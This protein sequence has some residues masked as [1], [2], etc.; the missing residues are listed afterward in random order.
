MLSQS[1][2]LNV[3]FSSGRKVCI[4]LDS[5]IRVNEHDMFITYLPTKRHSLIVSPRVC[6]DDVRSAYRSTGSISLTVID[7]S[8]N[9][10][11]VV[12]T[13]IPDD[14]IVSRVAAKVC[15]KFIKINVYSVM[16]PI[17]IVD[18]YNGSV[19]R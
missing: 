18:I 8:Y 11:V 19:T 1:D 4:I 15:C 7:Y 14:N 6:V 3:I 2:V 16:E 17:D 9:R 10:R 5:K 13:P 12:A